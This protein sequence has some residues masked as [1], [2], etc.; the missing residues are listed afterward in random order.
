MR[1]RVSGRYV[2]TSDVEACPRVRGCVCTSEGACARVRDARVRVRERVCAGG[3]KFTRFAQREMFHQK[4]K[5]WLVGP[6]R[7]G[8]FG[9]VN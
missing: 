8:L 3:G 7:K 5:I 4:I 2:C 6:V 1:V 9:S